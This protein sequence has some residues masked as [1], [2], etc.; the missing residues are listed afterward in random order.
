MSWTPGWKKWILIIAALLPFLG[1]AFLA[2][3]FAQKH[4]TWPFCQGYLE[5]A[6]NLADDSESASF[7]DGLAQIESGILDTHRYR[8]TKRTLSLTGGEVTWDQQSEGRD[9]GLSALGNGLLVAS[10]LGELLYIKERFDDYDVVSVQVPTPHEQFEESIRG[11]SYVESTERRSAITPS[12]F[13]VKD[14]QVVR[15]RRGGY[16]L[17]ASYHN[18][19][20]GEMCYSLKISY[21][22]LVVPGG[23]VKAESTWEDLYETSPCVE[24]KDKGSPFGG[25]VS[26][27]RMAISDATLFVTLGDFGHDGRPG[28]MNFPQDPTNPYGKTVRINLED[29]ESSIYTMGHRNPQGLHVDAEGRIWATEH[30]PKGGDELNLLEEGNNYGWPEVTYG[31]PYGEYTW[32]LSEEDEMHDGFE[33]PIFVWTPAIGPA[34]LTSVRGDLFEAW[35]SDLLVG[36]MGTHDLYRVRIRDD[37]VAFSERINI[38]WRVRDIAEMVDGTL[39]LKADR[40]T[41]VVLRPVEDV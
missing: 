14:I 22:D 8:I 37:H 20:P 12:W 24:L 26:G 33:E 17:Y 15:Q 31:M 2:G 29:G 38:G 4:C 23:K 6:K 19:Y 35:Q 40:N 1:A 36:A 41:L 32:P 21:V 30:G 34:Q 28:R 13:G 11:T 39:V 18:W 16:R 9:G 10:R 27:G 25:H 3:S 7:G 5:N